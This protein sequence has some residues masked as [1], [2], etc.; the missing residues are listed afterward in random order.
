MT[1]AEYQK[2]AHSTAQYPQIFVGESTV[3]SDF[4]YPAL[5]LAGEVG[6]VIEK[7]KKIVRNKNGVIDHKDLE[8]IEPELG[9][10]L[11]YLSEMCSAI[12]T[13]L[14]RVAELNIKK[15]SDRAKRG[16]IKSEG[17]NR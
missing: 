6:E 13:T 4:I 16:V 1:F 9:D 12:G 11:W 8:C 2:K 15:L 10:V 5:G 17:D 14:N 3:S 7:I